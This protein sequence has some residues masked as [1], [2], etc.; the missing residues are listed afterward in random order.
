MV[1]NKQQNLPCKQVVMTQKAIPVLF[2][3]VIRLLKMEIMQTLDQRLSSITTQL[4]HQL[5][6]NPPIQRQFP[7]SFN[8]HQMDTP[9][10]APPI[11]MMPN[12]QAI[13]PNQQ[14]TTFPNQQVSN[15]SNQSPTQYRMTTPNTVLN[16][17]VA[18][19]RAPTPNQH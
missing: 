11:F 6:I 3:E 1:V 2:L 5:Q 8:H 14:S 19:H 7:P 16:Q 10:R 15:I 4:N 12:Q 9:F 18:Q 17:Q 13:Y